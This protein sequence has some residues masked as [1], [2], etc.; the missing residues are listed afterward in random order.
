MVAVN[1]GMTFIWPLLSLFIHP[2]P[3]PPSFKRRSAGASIVC[4]RVSFLVLPFSRRDVALLSVLW[5]FV[6]ILGIR[7][8][9]ARRNFCSLYPFP[10]FAFEFEIF[11]NRTLFASHQFCFASFSQASTPF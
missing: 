3:L 5:F 10:F 1:S 4:L 7:L 2:S 9:D 11:A 8:F 6:V